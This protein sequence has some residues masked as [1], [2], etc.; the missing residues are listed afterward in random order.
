M[1]IGNENVVKSSS[2]QRTN[3]PLPPHPQP[4]TPI[5]WGMYFGRTLPFNAWTTTGSFNAWT[6]PGF[7]LVI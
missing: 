5:Y 1:L 6:T 4:A 3:S 7:Y 2:L